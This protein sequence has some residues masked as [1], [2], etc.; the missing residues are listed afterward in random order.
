LAASPVEA[1]SAIVYVDGSVIGMAAAIDLVGCDSIM[2]TAVVAVAEAGEGKR[3]CPLA[4]EPRL[5]AETATAI[6][7]CR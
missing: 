2:P 4:R 5:P 7:D 1:S 6:R 3:W